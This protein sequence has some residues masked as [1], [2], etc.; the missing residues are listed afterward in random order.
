MKRREFAI[1]LAAAPLL[2]HPAWA[3][4]EPVEGKDFIRLAQPVPV[5][6][7]GKIEVIE[8]FGYW[9]PHC[10]TLEPVLQAWVRKLPSDVNFRRSPV[11][12]QPSHEP[13]QKLYFALEAMG[14][15]QDMHAKVFDAVHRQGLR[16]D[17]EAGMAAFATANGVDKAKLTDTMKGFTVSSKVRMA[18]QLW[19]AYHLDGVPSIAVNGRFVT[20]PDKAGGDE[21]ALL[22]V[23]ALMRKSA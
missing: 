17:N 19:A 7:P 18:N 3:A 12:W 2:A 11:A 9:C 15:G 4:G 1:G 23:E 16:L 10:N 14:L 8:F 13:Y 5:A 22:V 6:V 20:G 21:R